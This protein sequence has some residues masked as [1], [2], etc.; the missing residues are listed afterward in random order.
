MIRLME[1]L[2]SGIMQ[3]W[4]IYLITDELENTNK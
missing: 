2:K 1:G 4:L 3:K